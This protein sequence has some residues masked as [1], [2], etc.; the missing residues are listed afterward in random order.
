MQ[1]KMQIKKSVRTVRQYGDIET[2]KIQIPCIGTE[3][4]CI[5]TERQRRAERK[6]R[7]KETV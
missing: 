4:Q 5:G 2:V 6:C 7:V 3:R 1:D